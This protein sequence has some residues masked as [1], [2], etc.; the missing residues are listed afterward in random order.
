MTRANGTETKKIVV[1]D[2]AA[3]RDVLKQGLET[4]IP[5]CAVDVAANGNEALERVRQDVP[6]FIILDIRMPGKTGLQVLQEIRATL[7]VPVI[8]FTVSA[9]QKKYGVL[10]SGRTKGESSTPA[11]LASPG[12]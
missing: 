2:D 9:T 5:H 6:D 10:P 3:L 8:M 4:S 1:D 11:V 7:N 12:T